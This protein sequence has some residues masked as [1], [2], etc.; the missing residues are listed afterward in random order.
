[1]CATPFQRVACYS[2][3]HA[4]DTSAARSSL[5]G[6]MRPLT[7]LMFSTRCAAPSAI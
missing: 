3:G 7:S 4:G 1:V 5:R 2:H 6:V